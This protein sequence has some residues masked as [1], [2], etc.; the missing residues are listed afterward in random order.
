[1][2]LQFNVSE[3]RSKGVAN[4]YIV[5]YLNPPPYRFQSVT[6]KVAAN[7]EEIAYGDLHGDECKGFPARYRKAVKLDEDILNISFESLGYLGKRPER[8]PGFLVVG[9]NDCNAD[10]LDS[11]LVVGKL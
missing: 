8:K 1:M 6:Y 10:S 11:Y 4:G 2:D 5:Y 7:R 3:W 9:L